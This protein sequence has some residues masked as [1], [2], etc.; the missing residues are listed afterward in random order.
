[1]TI[2]HVVVQAFVV[3]LLLT[4]PGVMSCNQSESNLETTT[5]RSDSMK[6]KSI[7]LSSATLQGNE[8]IQTNFGEIQL[9]ETYISKE[10]LV[11][12]N[13]QL[14]LQRAIE[15]YQWSLP[16]TTFQMWYNSHKEVYGGT[17]LSFVEN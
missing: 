7:P 11:K 2:S 17:D 1:M 16:L 10:S 13:D 15:V 8:L 9:T 12:L 14:E 4:T 5:R 6:K 3:L